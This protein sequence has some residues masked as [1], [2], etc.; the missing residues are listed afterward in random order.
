MNILILGGTSEARQLA[1][2]LIGMGHSVTTSLAGRTE[3]PI[4]PQGEVRIGGFGGAEGLADWLGANRIEQLIDA[5]HPFAAQISA[6]AVAASA[7]AGTPLIRLLRPQWSPLKGEEWRD[8][9]SADAAAKVLPSGA[10]VL[11]TTGHTGL[12][13]FAE[14]Q[15]CR[16][17]A[18]MIEPPAFALP[19]HMEAL[20]SRPPYSLNAEMDLLRAHSISHLVSKNSG[21]KQASAKLGAARQLGV[22]I[23]MIGRPAY[24]PAREVTSVEALL[25]AL[26]S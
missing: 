8:V 12:E 23:I 20:L 10:R 7:A 13:S 2:R 5:T 18:R 3:A 25:A 19:D 4:L 16:F 6:N 14:R 9:P 1:G 24:A 15:D 21:G 22:E 11:L 17:I 26:T